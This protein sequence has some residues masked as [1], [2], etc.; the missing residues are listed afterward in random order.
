MT[1]L[2]VLSMTLPSHDQ[3][4]AMFQLAK[5]HTDAALRW[6]KASWLRK[7]EYDRKLD[8]RKR[9]NSKA[10][11][12]LRKTSPG[13]LQQIMLPK[14]DLAILHVQEEGTLLL[15]LGAPRQFTPHQMIQVDGTLATILS[16]D[17]FSLIVRPLTPR[18]AWPTEATV[19]QHIHTT[20]TGV[21]M[22]ELET[23]WQ[24]FWQTSTPDTDDPTTLQ[25][26]LD[27]LPVVLPDDL[28]FWDDRLWL[29]AVTD[30]NAQ[31]AR[32]LD[33]VSAA[34]LQHM[35]SSATLAL[36]TVIQQDPHCF[37][38]LMVA[39]THPVPKAEP[40]IETKQIRPIT[41]LPQTYR[42]WSRAVAFVLL[43]TFGTKLPASV[44]GFLPGRG[45]A[46][47]S[48]AFQF[49]VE[50]AHWQ[51]Q[52]T[53][54][55]S[56][57]LI[58][59]FNTIKRPVAAAF[60][61]K[62]GA[63]QDLIN[64]WMGA[65]S[66]LKRF[67]TANRCDSALQPTNCGLPEGDALSVIGMIAVS[68]AWISYLQQYE[69]E[70]SLLS[71]ADNWGWHVARPSM[72]ET[73]IALTIEFVQMCG[74]SIDWSKSWAWATTAA[75][76]K[77]LHRILQ[78]LPA[79][80][81]VPCVSTA[82]E[83]GAQH[84][85]LGSPKLGKMQERLQ[86]AHRK[87]DILQRLPHAL[88]VKIHLIQAGVYAAAFYGVELVPLGKSH[89]DSLRTSVCA[90]LLGPS[91][92]RNSYVALLCMPGLLD[93]ELHVIKVAISAAQ[94][95]LRQCSETKRR[96]F[97]TVVCQHSGTSAK[98]RGPAGSL[99]HYLDRIDWQM[100]MDGNHHVSAFQKYPFLTMSKRQLTRCLLTSW[101]ADLLTLHS[102]RASWRGRSP[103]HPWETRRV[104]GQFEPMQQKLLLNELS[105][106]FQTAQ[107]QA[108]W[109]P[110]SS[111]RC[112]H[113]DDFDTR[114]HRIWDC[115]ATQHIRTAHQAF[116]QSLAFEGF[117]YHELPVIY[118][119]PHTEPFHVFCDHILPPLLDETLHTRLRSLL[120]SRTKFQFFTDGS[121]CNPV[122]ADGSHATFAVVVD[123]ASGDEERK[124]RAAEW[125]DTTRVPTLHTL[126]VARIP[127]EQ[128]I[129]RAEIAAMIHVCSHFPAADLVTD[130]QMA[131]ALGKHCLILEH[132]HPLYTHSEPDLALQLWELTRQGTYTFRKVKAH[133]DIQACTDMLLRYDR[134]GNHYADEA[135]QQAC[136]HMI[137]RLATEGNGIARDLQHQF[138]LLTAYYRYFLEL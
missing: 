99:R 30:L 133:Q 16:V 103:I 76:L 28:D 120:P 46:D 91:S 118:K 97:L 39:K 87:L 11:A 2:G 66:S 93:P 48:F 83:L 105:G 19:S 82:T 68:V 90:A 62:M 113:C 114:E 49:H 5:V 51:G 134:M 104:L 31:S 79:T 100:D 18:E 124:Q 64:R 73:I 43:Q 36:R 27:Q 13:D 119:H 132:P 12:R 106:A 95:F 52:P 22:T 75:Q 4:E 85:Y 69:P 14:E 109:D 21:M 115:L 107:Q 98:C 96:A 56:I 135:A 80:C 128:T 7:L 54:G 32:G 38:S 57:D 8:Q 70:A 33:C 138:D 60:L 81:E 45:P 42:L 72:H 41:V 121:C 116:L 35:P 47:S 101:S 77:S 126:H 20:D 94:R 78:Q 23:F 137:P 37:D 110:A 3:V 10:F 24:P 40:P 1:H 84:T 67:W 88:D 86:E 92:S 17:D 74:M 50:R 9:G 102:S 25:H 71:Y 6:D 123:L 53:S 108:K 125:T 63:S 130:S 112:P 131:C 136:S 44:T 122:V 89:T 127:G 55:M 58:K 15:Y 59:C 26:V 29:H 111:G 61:Q 65:L 117:D 129:H 34:E